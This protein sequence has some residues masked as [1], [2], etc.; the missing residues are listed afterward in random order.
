MAQNEAIRRTRLIE[1]SRTRLFAQPW[2]VALTYLVALFI[3]EAV[4]TLISPQA[5]MVL[6][7]F[8]L[9]ALLIQAAFTVR[10]R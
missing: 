10:Q 7:G 8:I 4:T 2:A 6:H 1:W 9:I 3:A 5:G